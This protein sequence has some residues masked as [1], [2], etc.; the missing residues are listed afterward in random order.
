M[1]D[2]SFKTKNLPQIKGVAGAHWEKLP[3]SSFPPV[4]DISIPGS[5]ANAIAANMSNIA[6]SVK[7]LNK[8]LEDITQ[9][10]QGLACSI[11]EFVDSLKGAQNLAEEFA[12]QNNNTRVYVRQIGLDP[13]GTIN[14][15]SNFIQQTRRALLDTGTDKDFKIPKLVAAEIPLDPKAIASALG[16]NQT[17]TEQLL[18]GGTNTLLQKKLGATISIGLNLPKLSNDIQFQ[19]LDKGG[20]FI[21]KGGSA[22]SYEVLSITKID[23]Q[24]GEITL[25]TSTISAISENQEITIEGTQSNNGSF[26]LVPNS[27]KKSLL[28]SLATNVRFFN[29]ATIGE[30]PPFGAKARLIDSLTT[31][32]VS[33]T[34]KIKHSLEQAGFYNSP[35]VPKTITA[36]KLLEIL[37]NYN[38]LNTNQDP[39]G[40]EKDKSTALER[41]SKLL[42]GKTQTLGGFVLVGKAPNIGS[43]VKKA[44]ALSSLME[45]LK[46]LSEKLATSALAQVVEAN[47]S[48]IDFDPTNINL[49]KLNKDNNVAKKD[50]EAAKQKIDNSG[51]KDFELPILE[52]E[53]I[54]Y[55][56]GK[57]NIWRKYSPVQLIPGMSALGELD[58]ELTDTIQSSAAAAI[59]ATTGTLGNLID[60]GKQKIDSFSNELEQGSY[61]I[62][63]TVDEINALSD[64][65]VQG[66]NFLKNLT[67]A[68]PTTL[69]GHLIGQKLLL[70]TNE[71]FVLAVEQA[72]NDFSDPNRPTFGPPPS[73]NFLE[74]QNQLKAALQGG[75]APTNNT[76]IWFG[77]LIVIIGRDRQ[78]LGEQMR[79]IGNLL[80]MDV[81]SIDLPPKPKFPSG[82]VAN[83]IK[84]GLS[85]I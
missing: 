69:E 42:T 24:V 26:K 66:M 5:T 43:L 49:T 73:P 58:E 55:P 53:K 47:P 68:G 15:Y 37:I 22:L 11:G 39:E 1:A 32:K 54:K 38:I 61:L 3:L 17:P 7:S 77:L 50:A 19:P 65:L 41:L 84:K 14:S 60:A 36:S 8:T 75:V 67:G 30:I 16:S 85:K 57:F 81:T 31:I 48:G 29:S 33:A 23:E 74:T 13:V 25:K 59:A 52:G 80:N 4:L 70:K 34:D 2:F 35:T 71:E 63:K 51:V 82:S 10:V 20:G 62:D 46:P 21:D 79:V 64:K 6:N 9:S 76:T 72:L 78:D 27:I 12:K 45:W 28:S 56:E 18:G 83:D 40:L 44:Q